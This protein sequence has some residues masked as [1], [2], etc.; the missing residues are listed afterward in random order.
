MVYDTWSLETQLKYK[1]SSMNNRQVVYEHTDTSNFKKVSLNTYPNLRKFRSTN[2]SSQVGGITSGL[3]T[4][5]ISY[6]LVD[7]PKRYRIS[8]TKKECAVKEKHATPED[9]LT[10]KQ[11]TVLDKFQRNVSEKDTYSYLNHKQTKAK[12]HSLLEQIFHEIDQF[13]LDAATADSWKRYT[14]S[15]AA[16]LGYKKAIRMM[17][18]WGLDK[19]QIMLDEFQENMPEKDADSYLNHKQ[20]KDK[21]HSLLEQIFYE[22][23]QF[24]LGTATADSRKR[25]TV[26]CAARLGYKKAICMMESWELNRSQGVVPNKGSVTYIRPRT[27]PKQNIRSV[28][29]NISKTRT[30]LIDG[31]Q[32]SIPKK[33]EVT[34]DKLDKIPEQN[35]RNKEECFAKVRA[36]MLEEYQLFI[37]KKE[38]VIHA[39]KEQIPKQNK[40]EE[41][42]HTK[43]EQISKQDRKKEVTHSRQEHIQKKNKKE[44]VSPVKKEHISKQTEKEDVSNVK[45]KHIPKQNKKKEA[46]HS[47][48]KQISR[49]NIRNARE[50]FTQAMNLMIQR[51]Q[52]L[53][54]EKEESAHVELDKIPEQN[55]R[56]AKE[57]FA[58]AMDLMKE[59]YQLS[60]PKKKE[61]THTKKEQIPEQNIRNAKEHFAKAMDLMKERYQLS[62]PKKKEVTHAKKEQIPEQNIRNANEHFTQA[63]NLM[64]Q[65]YQLS[66]PKKEESTYVELDKIPEQNIRN[67]KEHFA[68]A[69]D[70]M[71]ERYQLS[72]PKKQEVSCVKKECSTMLQTNNNT[73]ILK[74]SRKK[75][76]GEQGPKLGCSTG[77]DYVSKKKTIVKEE[78]LLKED[79]ILKQK[80]TTKKQQIKKKVTFKPIS[81]EASKSLII[82]GEYK[83]ELFDEKKRDIIISRD[84]HIEEKHKTIDTEEKQ[85]VDIRQKSPVPAKKIVS[86]SKNIT[87]VDSTP[88]VVIANTKPATSTEKE[89]ITKKSSVPTKEIISNFKIIAPVNIIP[90][91]VITKT[92]PISP[93]EKEDTTKKSSVPT[94][95]IVSNFKNTTS[96]NSTP[97]V[98]VTKTEPASSAKQKNIRTQKHKS[99]VEKNK[100]LFSKKEEDV[101]NQSAIPTKEIISNF[102]IINPVNI[103][104]PT[105]ITKTEAVSSTEKEDTTKKSSVPTQEIVSHSKNITPMDSIPTVVVTKTGPASSAKQNNIVTQKPKSGIEKIKLLFAKKE[106]D[107]TKKSS[108]PAKEIVSNF[109]TITPVNIIPP[110]VTTK[111]ESVSFNE[112]KNVPK[113]NNQSGLQKFTSFFKF[114]KKD[115]S[116]LSSSQPHSCIVKEQKAPKEVQKSQKIPELCP[117]MVDDVRKK[118]YEVYPSQKDPSETRQH[119]PDKPLAPGLR[120]L[121]D[122]KITNEPYRYL[123]RGTNK[124]EIF[125]PYYVPIDDS[126]YD[127]SL[128]DDTEYILETVLAKMV[129]RDGWKGR[130]ENFKSSCEYMSFATDCIVLD[131]TVLNGIRN[132]SNYVGS[133][134]SK[135]WKKDTKDS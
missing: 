25:Y 119:Y 93:T 84:K 65:R 85:K 56:N 53:V 16:R 58:K 133:A 31:Y 66:I 88:A 47:K 134:I 10:K 29:E 107:T 2:P 59:R 123:D 30:H 37:P 73:I 18:S 62:V 35:I 14:V 99:D 17:E 46:T 1:P 103:I 3:R 22:I 60:V 7:I 61:V 116:E 71:K 13:G 48:Q 8:C 98:V 81:P 40:K 39:K 129:K 97:A 132:G 110:T 96:V 86:H 94:Q 26:S 55:I 74:S 43:N 69:M 109:K 82:I 76:K 117:D 21:E 72:V 19:S 68:N 63:M 50:H 100:L 54:P 5:V 90:P 38:E 128:F 15:C 121:I 57:H 131:S 127:S 45:K 11:V 20:T 49:Q 36:P 105:V 12:E 51:Y 111:T 91:V 108:I 104:P 83:K 24:G 77:K 112:T 95:E 122:S 33:E 28:E 41:V 52:L 34:H 124:V 42:A 126:M 79:Y 75:Q 118:F 102:K 114:H 115:P 106:E 4:L 27:I 113:P 64:T 92:E 120:E 89:D 67:A 87:P 32:L 125:D 6:G 9:T 44:D 101:T 23:D 80:Q 130:M 78:S 135:L 70:L